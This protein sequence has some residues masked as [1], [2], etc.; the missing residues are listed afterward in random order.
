MKSDPEPVSGNGSPPTVN[1][2]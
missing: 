1:H 2:S